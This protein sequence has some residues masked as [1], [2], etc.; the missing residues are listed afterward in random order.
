MYA[1]PAE[2]P[3]SCP[4]L[5]SVDQR[6]PIPTGGYK[7]TSNTSRLVFR[8]FQ[9]N[10]SMLG[11]YSSK[12][13]RDVLQL[14]VAFLRSQEGSNLSETAVPVQEW[15]ADRSNPRQAVVGWESLVRELIEISDIPG[16]HFELFLP[17]NVEEVSRKITQGCDYLGRRANN[18]LDM[19][20]HE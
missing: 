19:F 12:A 8:Q 14:K 5:G 6:G 16:N 1:W 9:L 10:S 20:V 4:S 17:A 11:H 18:G 15:S 3:W 2:S 7:V 13:H